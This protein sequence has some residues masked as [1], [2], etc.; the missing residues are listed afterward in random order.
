MIAQLYGILGQENAIGLGNSQI[1]CTV[2]QDS[3]VRNCHRFGIIAQLSEILRQTCRL[4][5][6]PGKKLLVSQCLGVAMLKVRHIYDAM[7]SD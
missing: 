1:N 3:G 6:E 2:I 7:L 4:R 5:D